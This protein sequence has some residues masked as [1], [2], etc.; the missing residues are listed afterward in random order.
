MTIRALALFCPLFQIELLKLL[1]HNLN[2]GEFTMSS[3][4]ETTQ[5]NNEFDL[6]A[7]FDAEN[8]LYFYGKSRM[9]ESAE[10]EIKF[11]I[12]KVN[13]QKE[14]KILDLACGHG[15]HSN[16]FAE[17]GFDITGFDINQDFLNIARTDATEKRL[18]VEFI[19]GDMRT[20][21][22]EEEFHRILLIFTAFGYFSDS[23]NKLI[24]MNI[25]KALKKNGLF[26][27]DVQN[28]DY[29]IKALQPFGILEKDG[30]YMLESRSFDILTGR[31]NTKRTYIKDNR[32]SVANISLREYSYTELKI[33]LDSVGF[34]IKDVYGSWNADEFSKDS[35]RMIIIAE[36]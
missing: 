16:K 15:R 19:H 12:E 28:R 20:L 25:Y 33:I 5:G 17:M 22:F 31:I 3:E 26:C 29:L 8:Y 14:M 9:D 32:T 21:E 4:N 34:K 24:L 23:E 27:F 36:K 7:V 18:N 30:N 35:P 6:D 1:C 10:K 2:D 11:L 13:I